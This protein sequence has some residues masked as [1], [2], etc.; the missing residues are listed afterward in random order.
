MALEWLYR[1]SL[2]LNLMFVKLKKNI[3]KI[4][5][6]YMS[7]LKKLIYFITTI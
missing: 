2:I 4:A 5:N 6:F 3:L 7:I 1:D